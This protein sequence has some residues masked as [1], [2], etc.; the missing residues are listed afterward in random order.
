[1]FFESWYGLLRVVVVAPLAYGGLVLILRVSGKRTLA[2]LN[3][4]DLV[5]TVALGSTLATILLSK[6]VPL[7]EGLAA[8]II[9]AAM[10]FVVAWLSVR[11]SWFSNLVRSEPTLLLHNGEFLD[12]ALLAQRVTRDDVKAALRSSGVGDPN[13]ASAVVLE[14]DGSISVIK[15]KAAAS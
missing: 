12:R 15:A 10:Q 5:V 9:L 4:F 13:E 6:T 14:T 3:A 7:L 2:K 11:V 8:F 1:M